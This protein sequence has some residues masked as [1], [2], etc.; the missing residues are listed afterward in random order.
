MRDLIQADYAA[1]AKAVNS[2]TYNKTQIQL[3]VLDPDVRELSD[4][5][6][7][8]KEQFA[9][10]SAA[11]TLNKPINKKNELEKEMTGDRVKISVDE[12]DERAIMQNE[13]KNY[14]FIVDKTPDKDLTAINQGQTK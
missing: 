5:M 7:F 12:L 13:L 6:D 4:S 2:A 11:A 14:N 8:Q 3:Y 9:T 10:M 1:M